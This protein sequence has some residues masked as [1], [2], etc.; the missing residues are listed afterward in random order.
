MSRNE[1]KGPIV[2][3]G[4]MRYTVAA[5]SEWVD[6]YRV[7]RP[8]GEVHAWTCCMAGARLRGDTPQRRG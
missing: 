4:Y 3:S 8:D 5:S 2:Q 1:V 7:R 6:P